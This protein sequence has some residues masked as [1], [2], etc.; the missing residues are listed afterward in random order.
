MKIRYS[1]T[2][3]GSSTMSYQGPANTANEL[4]DKMGLTIIFN[5]RDYY[6]FGTPLQ[7]LII[8]TDVESGALLRQCDPRAYIMKNNPS[9]KN[10][11]QNRVKNLVTQLNEGKV[12]FDDVFNA[13]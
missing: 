5:N 6:I 4:V 12:N 2:F 10:L 7:A 13:S 1:A 8:E 9:F 3:S 11:T